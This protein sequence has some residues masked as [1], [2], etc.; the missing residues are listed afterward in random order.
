MLQNG[1]DFA[2]D[3]HRVALGARLGNFDRRYFTSRQYLPKAG[4]ISKEL[5]E[6]MLERAL[7]G[8]YH[9][10]A[11]IQ[12]YAAAINAGDWQELISDQ[13]AFS[14]DGKLLNGY[15]RLKA[16]V[17]TGKTLRNASIAFGLDPAV[18]SVIDTGMGQ[19]TKHKLLLANVPKTLV[20][21]MSQGLGLYLCYDAALKEGKFPRKSRFTPQKEHDF[22]IANPK[23]KLMAEEVMGLTQKNWREVLPPAVVI[24][25]AFMAVEKGH[26]Q[27]VALGFIKLIGN[28]ETGNQRH[29]AWALYKHLQRLKEGMRN[30]EKKLAKAVRCFNKWA[31]KGEMS[32]VIGIIEPGNKA[33]WNADIPLEERVEIPAVIKYTRNHHRHANEVN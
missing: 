2:T 27:D 5:A 4:D 16:I 33:E 18:Y 32:R 29:P 13:I 28:P 24:C 30:R 9:S 7:P 20:Q 10:N 8:Q 1:D 23:F 31:Q 21:P 6:E 22:H 26:P 17:L 15:H 12:Q 3:E 11:R 14:W 25:L 19:K